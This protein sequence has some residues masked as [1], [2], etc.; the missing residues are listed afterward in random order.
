MNYF[1]T[2]GVMIDCS[3]NAVMSV[4][5]LK[6]FFQILK[7]MGYNQVQ[8]YMEDTYEV[9]TELEAKQLIEDAKQNVEF[10]LESE[11]GIGTEITVYLPMDPQNV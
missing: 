10:E 4:K 9:E 3:R 5:S 6:K 1:D 2:F 11:L 8:L 7:K